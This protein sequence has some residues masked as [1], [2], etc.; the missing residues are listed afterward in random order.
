[1]FAGETNHARNPMIGWQ[2]LRAGVIELARVADDQD[3][4]D[5]GAFGHN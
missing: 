5:V 3:A 2:T 1:M 4:V